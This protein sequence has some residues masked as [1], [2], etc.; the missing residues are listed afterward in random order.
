MLALTP[1]TSLP[2]SARRKPGFFIVVQTRSCTLR[3]SGSAPSPRAWTP[4]TTAPPPGSC[5][6]P[7]PSG[8]GRPSGTGSGP[9]STEPRQRAGSEAGPRRWTLRSCGPSG[10]SWQRRLGKRGRPSVPGEPTHREGGQGTDTSGDSAVRPRRAVPRR[11]DR[12]TKPSSSTISRLRRDICRCRL[13]SRLSSL[14][15]SGPL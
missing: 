5:C 12:G 10:T 9:A 14:A 15:P 11:G 2:P 3:G 13:S 4:E 6:Y 7:W 8:R 1:R